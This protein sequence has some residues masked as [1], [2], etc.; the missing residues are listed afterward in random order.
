MNLNPELLAR[1]ERVNV[2][3]KDK[4]SII[5]V[6]FSLYQ[7]VLRSLAPFILNRLVNSN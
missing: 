6:S 7:C 5:A 3:S 2:Y 4:H 1:S